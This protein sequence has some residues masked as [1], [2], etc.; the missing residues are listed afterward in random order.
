MFIKNEISK[1]RLEKCSTSS[2]K[3]DL[4]FF[5]NLLDDSCYYPASGADISPIKYLEK[6]DSFVYCDYIHLNNELLKKTIIDEFNNA[7]IIRQERIFLEEFGFKESLELD[8]KI[9]NEFQDNQLDKIKGLIARRF[10]EW[11]LWEI[12]S[13]LVSIMYISW[14]GVDC[15]RKLY[16]KNN[17][18]PSVLCIIQPGHTMGG[19]WTD[20]FDPNGQFL[21]TV[22]ESI[23]PPYMLLGCYSGSQLQIHFD[24]KKYLRVAGS[25]VTIS[26][27][28]NTEKHYL[29]LVRQD[30]RTDEEKE[31]DIRKNIF[32]KK[33]NARLRQIIYDEW[34]KIYQAKRLENKRFPDPPIHLRHEE[35][36]RK[37]EFDKSIKQ[38][39]YKYKIRNAIRRND[40]QAIESLRR[41]LSVN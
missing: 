38:R 12:D 7:K 4:E 40:T 41:K 8:A 17:K 14:E 13:R 2:F 16:L 31:S 24:S 1:C 20:F 35:N 18:Y 27:A 25:E 21:S 28:S 33:K 15:Y 19:N 30:E 23:A 10:G 34:W 22:C 26:N 37:Q 6:I 5:R 3:F 39:D 32:E 36:I 11:S 29:F 9:I